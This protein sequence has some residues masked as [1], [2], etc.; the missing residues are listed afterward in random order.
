M[1]IT[2]DEY[3]ALHLDADYWS[4]QEETKRAA[5]LAMA[6]QI[7]ET[8][9]TRLIHY[10]GTTSVP[11]FSETH[12]EPIDACVDVVSYM[13]PTL[14]AVSPREFTLSA[15]GKTYI[16]RSFDELLQKIA[17]LP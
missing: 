3:F 7:R 13:Y 15:S 1:A 4:S 17:C 10:E 16:C 11:R 12:E 2:P 9:S 8:D 14:E 6:E 5:A